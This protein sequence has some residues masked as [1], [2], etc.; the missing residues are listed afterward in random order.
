MSI[1]ALGMD[2][3]TGLAVS[4]LD[5]IRM[6]I[7]QI[8]MTP[9]G[10]RIERRE[11]GSLIPDMIDAPLNDVWIMRLIAAS[12]HAILRW[13]PR[14]ALQSL[15]IDLDTTNHGTLTLTMQATVID[16]DGTVSLQVPL[17]L[18]GST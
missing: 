18:G 12:A 14:V 6:C 7:R 13:E 3:S 10:S 8:L 5:H 16:S 4:G 2:P 11:F 15:S 17:S 1:A 9:I